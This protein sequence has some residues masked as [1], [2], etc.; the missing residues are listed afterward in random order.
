MRSFIKQ[1]GFAPADK[2]YLGFLHWRHDAALDAVRSRIS[3][4]LGLPPENMV[5]NCLSTVA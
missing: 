5:R 4:V 2:T 3:R 1:D